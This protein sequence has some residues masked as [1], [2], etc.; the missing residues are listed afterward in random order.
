VTNAAVAAELRPS[1]WSP[2]RYEVFRALW[3][4][5]LVSD[6]G[7][8]M[9]QVGEGWLMT[10][11]SHSP[12]LV[13]LLQSADSLAVFLFSIPAGAIADVMDRRRLAIL[14]QAWLLVAAFCLG[15]LTLGGAITP[16]LLLTLS[17]VMNIGTA[18]D[19]PVWQAIVPELVP[20]SDLP[21]AVA[22]GGVS[23]NIARAVAPALG[24]LLVAAVGPYAVFF[25]NATTFAFVILVLARWRPHRS[26][27]T[28]PPERFAG[29]VLHGLRYV[30]HSPDLL[31]T[32][33]GVGIV[34]FCGSSVLALLPVYAQQELSLDSGGYGLLYGCMGLGAILSVALLPKVQKKLSADAVLVLASIGLAA[35]LVALAGLRNPWW[36]GG[37]M[38]IGGVAW[39]SILTGLN[40]AVQAATPSWVRA[41]VLSIYMVVFQGAIALGSVVWGALASKAN[42]RLSFLASGAIMLLSA[43]VGR[44]RWFKLSG[45]IPDLTP[46]L[47]WPKPVLVCTPSAEDGPVLVSV[48]YRVAPENQTA[49]IRAA[50]HV[51]R[52]RQRSGAY[53]WQLFR[54]PAVP[55][56]LVEVYLVDS[57]ADHL[58]QHER[59]TVDERNAEAR[60]RKLFVPGTDLVATHLIAATAEPEPES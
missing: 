9:H 1:A 14:T 18:L 2:L 50:D 6:I 54:D 47:H 12:L 8:W 38:L 17:F 35:A 10:T 59:V 43:L 16:W 19:A 27:S 28:L 26:K 48:E 11:L 23:I 15:L 4:A 46:S 58:R 7:A 30:R 31:S 24:G 37:A 25:L 41:R 36:A 42:L 45:R 13:A 49:F 22:L 40:V 44:R 29:A 52:R 60:L 21:Q 33:T 55:D 5:G 3:I 39:L 32:F 56:R 20:R 53:E 57:W 34:V 51:R